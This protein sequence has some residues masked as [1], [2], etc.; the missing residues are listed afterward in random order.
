[1]ATK[2]SFFTV[3][4][5]G[6]YLFEIPDFKLGN[7]SSTNMVIPAK[8]FIPFGFRKE[9]TTSVDYKDSAHPN[10][11]LEKTEEEARLEAFKLLIDELTKE[12]ED[13]DEQAYILI[14]IFESVN[15]VQHNQWFIKAE[16]Q[17]LLR[18]MPPA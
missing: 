15:Y 2:V 4:K 8:E 5:H 16:Y 9:K 10:I 7:L 14:N 11:D 6:R 1:M 3:S 18:T 12:A 13:F 17:F